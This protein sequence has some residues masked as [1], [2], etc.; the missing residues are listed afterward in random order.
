[1]GAPPR[2]AHARI[3]RTA[4]LVSGFLAFAA[5]AA[6]AGPPD[7]ARF[8]ASIY[9]DGREGAAWS[10]WLD[11]KRRGEWFSHALTALWARCDMRARTIDGELGALDFDV[12]T[13]S[14][15]L[16]L[17]SFTVKSLSRD[18]SHASVVAN[19]TP[20]NWVRHS[21]RENEIHYDLVWERGRWKIDDTA[22]PCAE[23]AAMLF[24]AL[25]ASGQIA[26]RKVDGWQS[27][28]EKPDDQII[29][30]AA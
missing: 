4:A 17:K 19:L 5:I 15:G 14:Q 24:W 13:N 28:A 16:K 25:L 2:T 12:A 23:T 26:M 22:L 9:A 1:M 29:D 10:Q 7:P 21:D 6:Q 8:V 11:G 20:D 30:L 3:A 27:L 18:A